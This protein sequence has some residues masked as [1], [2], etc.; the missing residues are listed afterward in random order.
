MP[1]KVGF[2]ES[3]KSF[4]LF[5]TFLSEAAFCDADFLVFAPD[6]YYNFGK[7]PTYRI[8]KQRTFLDSLKLIGRSQ[9]E[10]V[11]DIGGLVKYLLQNDIFI[12]NSN[13]TVVF[14]YINSI[15]SVVNNLIIRANK[16]LFDGFLKILNIAKEVLQLEIKDKEILIDFKVSEIIDDS[17]ISSK[18]SVFKSIKEFGLNSAICL[19]IDVEVFLEKD[20]ST[21]EIL[22][23]IENLADLKLIKLTNLEFF[24]KICKKPKKFNQSKIVNAMVNFFNFNKIKNI[25][26]AV[27]RNKEISNKFITLFI[28]TLK[29]EVIEPAKLED[30]LKIIDEIE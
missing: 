26:V 11:F 19:E 24:N 29:S 4:R 9:N 10:I 17:Y 3:T 28:N 30:S 8:L 16:E 23:R 1:R 15:Y 13:K 7:L 20:C 5:E 27:E 2:V 18:N 21:K 25:P 22:S 12:K 14:K 6:K